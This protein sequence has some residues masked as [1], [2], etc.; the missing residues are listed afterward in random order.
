MEFDRRLRRPGWLCLV[1]FDQSVHH[2]S[3][4]RQRGEVFRQEKCEFTATAFQALDPNLPTKPPSQFATNGEAEP[5]S[6]IFSTRASIGLLKR[7]EDG[8][9]FVVW[10]SN[11]TVT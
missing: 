6:A 1:R 2:R 9:L 10:D 7:L 8:G 11:S 4:S 3:F 5:G